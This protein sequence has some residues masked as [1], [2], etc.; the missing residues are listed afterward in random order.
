MAAPRGP[1]QAVYDACLDPTV[2]GRVGE[3]PDR[4]SVVQNERDCLQRRWR[5]LACRLLLKRRRERQTPMENR[6][7]PARTSP[8][9]R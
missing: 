6:L 4:Q 5:L 3:G 1:R 8:R 7:L 2:L 9:P